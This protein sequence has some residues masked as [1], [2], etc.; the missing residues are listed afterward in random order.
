MGLGIPE[1]SAKTIV[2]GASNP[3]DGAANLD[4]FG[5]IQQG[6]HRSGAGV[7]ANGSDT[8]GLGECEHWW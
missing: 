4:C 6:S 3:R 5:A 8:Q 1:Y 7:V 2:E